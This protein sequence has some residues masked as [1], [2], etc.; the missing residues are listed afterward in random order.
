MDLT[1]LKEKLGG[2]PLAI[3]GLGQSGMATLEA[4]L[5]AGI[6]VYAWDD[7]ADNVATAKAKGATVEPLTQEIL[8][9]C[10][11]LLLA[12][13]VPLTHPKPHEVVVAAKAVKLPV[14]SDIELFHLA[15]PKART[16][17][18]TGTNGKSTTTALITHILKEAGEDVVMGGNIG[19][20]VMG[21]K[22][23]TEKTVYVLE[24][25][26]YQL[27]LCDRFA[28]MISILI[29]MS[30]DHLDR[31]GDMAG[32]QAAK[33]RIFH[34][35]GSAVIGIDD[36]WSK[37]IAERV[38]AKGTRA[39]TFV[40]VKEKLAQGVY[41]DENGFLYDDGRKICDLK[42][43]PNLVGA[44]NWQ[45][46]GVAYQALKEYGLAESAIIHGLQ[47]YGGL[48]H[49]QFT[50]ET[51]NDIRYINDSKA[52]NDDAAAVALSAYETIYWLAGG[53]SK[54][55]G[56]ESCAAQ[57]KHVRH[58][59]LIGAAAEEMAAWLKT[60]G[61][62]YTVAHTLEA[63]LQLAHEM[64]QDEKIKG[65]VVM[66][67]PACASFDQFKSFEHRGEVFESLV[68]AIAKQCQPTKHNGLKR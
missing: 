18:I 12:P 20:A 43:C 5:S 10:A 58:A 46:A 2:K 21:L 26:S 23:P 34:H 41:V 68:R 63:A 45:N 64:A 24:L 27:D 37:E 67:S 16:I 65:A 15:Y 48:A 11:Y 66:L 22:S 1:V 54:G 61:I 35:Q 14:I 32:Y 13:G 60:R 49:R 36:I 28:P 29:N 31:H 50:V 7:N 44:H 4:A 57:L 59:F 3:F 51:M 62:P 6:A 40:S 53:K 17:G 30:K 42:T 55:G 25:S 8:T 38:Q 39:V 47:T 33:A 19:E 52:T 56:Y 9:G